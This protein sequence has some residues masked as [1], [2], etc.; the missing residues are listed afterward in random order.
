LSTT[1][2]V[3][4]PGRLS[5]D[6]LLPD[7]AAALEREL[8]RPI[9]P[10]EVVS[11]TE[12]TYSSV[13]ELRSGRDR[14]ILKWV[15]LRTERELELTRLTRTLFAAVPFV[16]V[17]AVAVCPTPETFLVE[18][19]PGAH[20]QAV[21]T[22][23]PWMGVSTWLDARCAALS[24]VGV[25]LKTFH[26]SA[27]AQEAGPLDGVRAYVLKR[28]RAFP[29]SV[30][31]LLD[32]L[33]LAIGRCSAT[34]TV[35][36]H[37]DFTPHNVLVTENTISVIDLAGISEFERETRWFDVGAMMVGIEE[38]WRRRTVNHLRFFSSHV[39]AMLKAFGAGY[40]VHADLGA[41]SVCYSVR[42]FAR[43]ATR[44]KQTGRQPTARDWHVRRLVLGLERPEAVNALL[45]GD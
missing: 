9:G 32:E 7:A 39:G 1:T 18:K 44:F 14:F 3:T 21:S 15:P 11:A 28:E 26:A 27:V 40:A 38:T 29:P 16:R 23:P 42:H 45:F 20:L 2:H 35:R 10:L 13:W 41:L 22:R 24:R 8:G 17:P 43:I 25:W 37:G 6:R 31:S 34:E 33:L 19:L 5:I 12:R 30:R 4:Q 36:V